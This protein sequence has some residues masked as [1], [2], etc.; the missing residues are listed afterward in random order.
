MIIV[1]LIQKQSWMKAHSHDVDFQIEIFLYDL[2]YI[3]DIIDLNV[4]ISYVNI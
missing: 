4:Y 3:Y 2:S 1:L